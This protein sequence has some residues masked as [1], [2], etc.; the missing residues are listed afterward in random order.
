LLA[1]AEYDRQSSSFS[2]RDVSVSSIL[3]E[4]N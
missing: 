1:A 4:N 2:A 3:K